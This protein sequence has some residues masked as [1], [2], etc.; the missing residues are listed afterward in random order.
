MEKESGAVKV[1]KNTISL[2]VRTIFLTLISLFSF[3][4]ILRSLGAADYGLY[5]VV[6]GVIS[7]FSFIT[8]SLAISSQRFFAICLAKEDWNKLNKLFSVN[9]A[10]YMVLIV[11]VLFLAETL[12]L[13][14]VQTQLK[15]DA[16]RRFAAVIVYELSVINFSLGLLISP[17]LALLIAD[18]NLSIYSMVSVVEGILKVAVAYFL[19]VTKGDK[20]IVYAL[21]LTATSFI[22]NG[23]YIV[24]VIKKYPKLKFKLCREKAE[25]APVFSFLNWNLIGAV[26][27]I[28]K[29]QGIKIIINMFFG[30]VVNGAKGVA[31]QVS[32][33]ISSF[34]QNFMKAVEPRITKSYAGEDKGRYLSTIYTASKLS[35][36]LL[37]IISLPFMMNIQYVMNLWLEEVPDNTI[38]FTILILT[39][40]LILSITD[41]ILTGVQAIGRVKIYQLTVGILALL[42]LP[43]SILMLKL[44]RNPIIPFCVS[45][46]I[47]IL[48]TIG[49]ILNIKR[50]YDFSITMY[51]RKV[52]VPIFVV[53]AA[54]IIG[55]KLLFAGASSFGR[56]VVN[57][58][59][60]LCITVP[61][62]YLIGMDKR[63]KEVIKEYFR[64][65]KNK[66]NV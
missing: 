45:I 57:V 38:I 51:V 65:R 39:D 17:F 55:D 52:F 1:L 66:E 16:G 61:A 18:E 28:L 60:S 12:G 33:T 40:C 19:N 2:Y 46:G 14:F 23:F 26:A 20:L 41:S 9:L 31:S 44:I 10:I 7:M 50:I 64:F 13:W 35:Y 49:R 37:F 56:L 30:S 8:G 15:I 59:G 53:T 36:F 25:Y 6:G 4:I 43:V 34:S 5:D 62:I 47:S 24:Y 54:G 48:M 27:S 21:L 42:N 58:A 29:N 63:E 3:R 22:I 11:V 32:N